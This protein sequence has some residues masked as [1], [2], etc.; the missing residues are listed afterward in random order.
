MRANPTASAPWP[1]YDGGMTEADWLSNRSRPAELL[2]HA[3][4]HARRR[5]LILLGCAC[6]RL[7][8]DRLDEAGRAAVEAAERAADSSDIPPPDPNALISDPPAW[9]GDVPLAAEAARNVVW[10]ATHPD[11]W[12]GVDRAV[13]WVQTFAARTT[14]GGQVKATL[15][16]TRARICDLIREVVGNPFRPWQVLPPHLGPGLIQPDGRTVRLT[17]AV[18]HIAAAIH[19]ERA[20]DRL[21]VLADA[22]EEAGITDPAMLEHLRFGTGHALGCWALDLLRGN[23]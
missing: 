8:W 15:E 14:I 4:R 21:P 20:F 18:S 3:R 23:G 1:R 19:A 5:K 7:V 16:S 9:G 12:N 2:R 10:A 11:L 6:G 22:A 17:E 13:G